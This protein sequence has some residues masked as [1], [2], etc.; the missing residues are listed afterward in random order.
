MP[1]IASA[2]ANVRLVWIVIGEF[3]C[4]VSYRVA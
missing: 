4:S 1:T 3:L 2:I